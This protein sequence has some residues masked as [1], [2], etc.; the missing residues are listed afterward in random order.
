M[1]KEP[2]ATAEKTLEELWEEGC[3]L[4]L[5]EEMKEILSNEMKRR[6]LRNPLLP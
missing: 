5:Q 6:G 1:T 2:Q 4:G 3:K